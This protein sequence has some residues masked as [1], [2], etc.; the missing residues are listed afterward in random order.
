MSR[1]G[2]HS[3]SIGGAPRLTDKVAIQVLFARTSCPSTASRLVTHIDV[4]AGC[5]SGRD[6]K[7]VRVCPPS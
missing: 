7:R 6:Q 2:W 1:P 5:I 4:D 3:P